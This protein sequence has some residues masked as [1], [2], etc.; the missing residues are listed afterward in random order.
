LN[1]FSDHSQGTEK[2]AW[3]NAHLCED[4]LVVYD[5][6][7]QS[8]GMPFFHDVLGKGGELVCKGIPVT[9]LYMTRWPLMLLLCK[10]SIGGK[11]RERARECAHREIV[12][13]L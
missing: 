6:Q 5:C 12:F 4:A 7:G 13:A 2:W 9:P 11:Q 1:G 8:R 3:G 10:H